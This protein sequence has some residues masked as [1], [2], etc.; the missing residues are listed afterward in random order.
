MNAGEGV[1]LLVLAQNFLDH[2]V[3]RSGILSPRVADQPAEPDEIL[4]GVAQAIDVIEPQ[5]LQL[6]FFDQSLD[7]PMDGR[8]R[9]GVLDPQTCERIDVEEAAVVDVAGGE[10]PMA[11]PVVLAFQEVVQRE[12]RREAIRPRAIGGKSACDDL[13]ASRDGS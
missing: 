6:A 11:E 12:G 1:Q 13:T 10:P 4:R 2:Q 8:E 5:P 9:A 7:H 3:E